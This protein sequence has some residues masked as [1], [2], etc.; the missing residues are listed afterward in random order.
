MCICVHVA[1]GEQDREVQTE[2]AR[3]ANGIKSSTR[4]GAQKEIMGGKLLCVIDL[5]MCVSLLLLLC[6]S[7]T[8]IGS[9]AVDSIGRDCGHRLRVLR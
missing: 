3:P 8:L 2:K 4:L 1:A 6:V 9:P 7:H 5:A